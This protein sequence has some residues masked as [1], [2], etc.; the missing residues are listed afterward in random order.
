MKNIYSEN[1]SFSPFLSAGAN[2]VSK[3]SA[4]NQ[5][6]RNQGCIEKKKVCELF[7]KLSPIYN[8]FEVKPVTQPVKVKYF[9]FYRNTELKLK[10]DV[11]PERSESVF[12]LFFSR[13]I[14]Q[15]EYTDFV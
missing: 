12:R 9:P 5:G 13:A 10:A 15:L 4:Y 8:F 7:H 11:T 1:S 14:S 6:R 3:S 2:D